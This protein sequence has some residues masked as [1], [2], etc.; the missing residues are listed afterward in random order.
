M[1]KQLYSSYRIDGTSALDVAYEEQHQAHI[2]P[3]PLSASSLSESAN[4]SQ[5]HSSDVL[6]TETMTQSHVSQA[7]IIWSA[8][9]FSE[10]AYTIRHLSM[11]AFSG[12]AL[13]VLDKFLIAAVCIA[14]G[15][16][17]ILF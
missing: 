8:L 6:H 13:S 7:Q 2:I 16:C 17:M 5:I 1:M 14:A 11:A 10:I 4:T 3:F 9:G 15:F 12:K